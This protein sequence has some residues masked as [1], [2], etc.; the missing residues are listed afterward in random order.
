MARHSNGKNT[1][2]VA[3]WVLALLAALILALAVGAYFLFRGNDDASTTTAA[4]SS[5][6]EP[7]EETDAAISDA[8]ARDGQA[9]SSA[10]ESLSLIHI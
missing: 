6:V 7:A 10:A 8:A 4:A 2:A 1:F 3:G 9:E 5:A